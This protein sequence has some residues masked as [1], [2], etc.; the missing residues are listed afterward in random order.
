MFCCLPLALVEVRF[1]FS[2]FSPNA[3][4][5][6]VLIPNV[7]VVA[8]SPN[9]YISVVPHLGEWLEQ[10]CLD[11]SCS[12]FVLLFPP[13]LPSPPPASVAPFPLARCQTNRKSWRHILG[14]WPVLASGELIMFSNPRRDVKSSTTSY[15]GLIR[16]DRFFRYRREGAFHAFHRPFCSMALSSETPSP[17][18]NLGLGSGL[19]GPA[20]RL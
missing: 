12:H 15:D 20:L 6:S 11:P 8:I 14:I 5:L 19:D 4:S 17:P 7:I 1:R 3:Y 18:L 9:F 16:F 2:P 10:V 13:F